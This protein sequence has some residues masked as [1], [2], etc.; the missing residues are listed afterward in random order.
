MEEGDDI[1]KLFYFHFTK[2]TNETSRFP[3]HLHAS[4]PPLP[5]LHM[6]EVSFNPIFYFFLNLFF[7]FFSDLAA[8]TDDG[9]GHPLVNVLL[10]K[11]VLLL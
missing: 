7:S 2:I 5:H 3:S 9:A 6:Q 10:K 8:R 11:K 1:Y 4:W